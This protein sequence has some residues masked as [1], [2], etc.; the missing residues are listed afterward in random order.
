MSKVVVWDTTYEAKTL[1]YTIIQVFPTSKLESSPSQ[2]HLKLYVQGTRKRNLWSYPTSQP[3]LLVLGVQ[4]SMPYILTLLET[5]VELV[6]LASLHSIT[7]NHYLYKH[8]DISFKI[9]GSHFE[10]LPY[11]P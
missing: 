8:L 4:A 10:T 6:L 7:Q 5:I 2:I 1:S 9:H 11:S 3:S